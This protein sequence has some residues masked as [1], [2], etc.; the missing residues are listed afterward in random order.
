MLAGQHPLR[1][2][3]DL[4]V[5]KDRREIPVLPVRLVLKVQLVQ[6]VLKVLRERLALK[7]HKEIPV[8]PALVALSGILVAALLAPSLECSRTICISILLAGMST[9]TDGLGEGQ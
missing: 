3:Q 8:P 6:P 1:D 4:L 5:L 9:N 7:V 2:Q